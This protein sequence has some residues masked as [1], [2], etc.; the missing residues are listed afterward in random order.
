MPEYHW[1]W[2]QSKIKKIK[3]VPN[4]QGG[5]DLEYM[6]ACSSFNILDYK[7]HWV[8]RAPSTDE[9]LVYWDIKAFISS[10]WMGNFLDSQNWAPLETSL[11]KISPKLK[12]QGREVHLIIF[13]L[14]LKPVNNL[15]DM[16]QS[17]LILV[18]SFRTQYQKRELLDLEDLRRLLIVLD[19]ISKLTLKGIKFHS[20]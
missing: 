18:S 11:S 3:Q 16:I 5:K 19:W 4:S 14:L 1:M 6:Q 10:K 9:G 12:C 7:Q 2:P 13:Q 8:C 15:G 20:A 17:I